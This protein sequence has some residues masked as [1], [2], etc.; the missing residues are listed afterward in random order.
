M[1]YGAF[2]HIHSI[3]RGTSFGLH[4]S[5]GVVLCRHMNETRRFENK[6]RGIIIH[7]GKLL[8]FK[9]NKED[10]FYSLPGGR[11][12]PNGEDLYQS[13]EREMI[14]ETGIKPVIGKLLFIQQLFLRD[15]TIIEFIFEIEN[16]S[17]YLNIDFSKATHGFEVV[18]AVF[19]DVED[20]EKQI[21]PAFL[22][23]EVV[24]MNKSGESRS[25]A[26]IYISRP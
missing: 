5:A 23:A 12:E 24:A 10:T 21:L 26:K 1:D 16:G 7:D 22:K 4:M 11:L 17:K 14:E 3:T 8:V 6:V 15:R 19:L 20:P 13:L 25:N 2:L 18:E 9:L